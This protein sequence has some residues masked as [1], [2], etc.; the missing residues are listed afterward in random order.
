MILKVVRSTD[1]TRGMILFQDGLDAFLL[2][3]GGCVL[4]GRK[5]TAK[6]HV[7]HTISSGQ[8][9]TMIVTVDLGLDYLPGCVCQFLPCEVSPLPFLEER[10]HELK[11][12]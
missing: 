2:N 12:R 4:L 10:H 7:H 3:P 11:E 8:T 1:Q 9:V 6:Y 5:S